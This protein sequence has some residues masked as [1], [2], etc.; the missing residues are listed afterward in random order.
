M[1]HITFCALVERK[2]IWSDLLSWKCWINLFSERSPCEVQLAWTME[3]G[4]FFFLVLFV[5]VFV[6]EVVTRNINKK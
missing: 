6:F 3:E 2:T 1:F 4:G 5:Y